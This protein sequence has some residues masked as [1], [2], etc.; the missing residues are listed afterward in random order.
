MTRE[1]LRHRQE[2]LITSEQEFQH[3][4]MDAQ[5]RENNAKQ[6]LNAQMQEYA[7]AASATLQC[8]QRQNSCGLQ[9]TQIR[10]LRQYSSTPIQQ[11]SPESPALPRQNQASLTALRSNKRSPSKNS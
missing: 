10:A 4:A 8:S 1:Y 6:T 5:T 9:E 7:A 11:Q 3:A 2:S